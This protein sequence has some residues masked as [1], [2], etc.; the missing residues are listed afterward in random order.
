MI[1]VYQPTLDGNEKTYVMDCLDSG[2]ISSKGK[3]GA[4][5]E[6]EFSRFSGIQHI[7]TVS[8]GTCAIQLA[9]ASLGIPPNTEII[10]PSFSYVAASSA[11]VRYGCIPVFA[12]VDEHTLQIDPKDVAAN[13]TN[14]TS[15]II[16]VHTYG[17]CYDSFAIDKIAKEF[18]LFHI[19]DCAE[20]IGTRSLSG[21]HVGNNSDFS[22][23]S[24]FANKTIT[25]GEGGLL[26]SRDAK[27]LD[28]A[29]SLKN[30][31]V[32][33]PGVYDHDDYGF[34]F[35]LT[36]I[37][38]AI[39]LAQLENI[40][41]K[42]SRKKEIA[43]SYKKHITDHPM[44]K[45]FDP[46]PSNNCH[47]YWMNTILTKDPQVSNI[48]RKALRDADIETRPLFTPVHL[49]VPYQRFSSKSCVVSESLH[50]CGFNLPSHPALSEHEVKLIADIINEAV[51][52]C[53]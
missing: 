34:N 40:S 18:G 10:L 49:M 23:F 42:L 52:N 26:C 36:N 2:W 27:L 31:S 14:K 35:R 38:A 33:A 3:Y 39:A 32:V 51:A 46:I 47:S 41:T 17:Y 45:V 16:G 5:L 15:C 29:V 8:N 30:H 21:A 9:L 22:T 13:I 43:A 44:L 4:M 6:E 1:N 28:K 53:H 25:A 19:E 12:D 7:T 48:L 24:L 37:A 50:H 20:A 11:V